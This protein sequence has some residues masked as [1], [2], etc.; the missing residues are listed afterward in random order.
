MD[1]N[2]VSEVHCPTQLPRRLSFPFVAAFTICVAIINQAKWSQMPI[3]MLISLCGYVVN[4]RASV[5]F[6]GASTISN[7]LGALTVGMSPYKNSLETKAHTILQV[8]WPTCIPDSA[9]TRGVLSMH[10]SRV[11]YPSS[12]I[13][14]TRALGVNVILR[15]ARKTLVPTCR[16][17]PRN[18]SRH[19]WD[20]A[21]R[22]QQCFLPFCEFLHATH[23]F[24]YS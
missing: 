12:N 24:T 11:G 9:G 4:W 8:F 13:G 17:P 2:A 1:K 23:L 6:K 19:K 22:R 16:V 3:M 18:A 7:T 15:K 5:Y 21:S 10:G 14:G 20:M